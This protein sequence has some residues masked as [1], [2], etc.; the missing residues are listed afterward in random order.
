MARPDA[1]A[2]F[3]QDKGQHQQAADQAAQADCSQSVEMDKNGLLRDIAK[4]P[5]G[6]GKQKQ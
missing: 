3:G 2:P 5:Q 6:G 4:A 1:C